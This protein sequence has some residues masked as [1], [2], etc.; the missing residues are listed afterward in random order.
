MNKLY[1]MMKNQNTNP[2]IKQFQEFR[3]NFKGDA[4]AQVEQ[5][6]NSGQITQEQYNKAVQMANQLKDM[7]N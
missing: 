6:L 7:M 3:N 2:M 5:M 1:G 4:K